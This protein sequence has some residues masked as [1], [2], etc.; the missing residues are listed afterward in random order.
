MIE[1]EKANY[2][3]SM[4]CD[5]LGVSKSGFHA[6]RNRVSSARDEE[7]ARLLTAIRRSW[8]LSNRTY[9]SP[10]IH[11]DLVD[12][13]WVVSQYRVARMMRQ[14]GIKGIKKGRYVHTTDSDHDLPIAPNLLDR[15]FDVD[16]PNKVWVSDICYIWTAQGFHYLCVVLDLF[17]R[18]IVGWAMDRSRNTELVLSALRRAVLFRQPD[19]GLLFHSDR[20]SQY[21]SYDFDEALTDYGFVQSMSRKGDCFDNA[22]VE[23]FFSTLRVELTYRH[24]WKTRVAPERYITYYI[25][26]FSNHPRRH[27][28]LGYLSP[29]QS[30]ELHTRVQ[31]DAA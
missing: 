19:P 7:N 28:T 21:A 17:N 29:A 5:A 14:N 3:V 12:D 18:E 25:S 1:A 11:E 23:S 2:S 26:S 22:V 24:R 4:M 8:M 13:G 20:G 9:G 16:A 10:R 15:N 6:W 31:S 27:S 30:R